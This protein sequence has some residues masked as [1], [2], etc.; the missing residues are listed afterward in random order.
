MQTVSGLIR[1]YRK[2]I[3][4]NREARRTYAIRETPYRR[5]HVEIVTQIIAEVRVAEHGIDNTTFGWH[6]YGLNGRAIIQ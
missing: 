6:A 5:T 4:V 1:I 2:S 3:A